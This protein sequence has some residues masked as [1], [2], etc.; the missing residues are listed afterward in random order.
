[1]PPGDFR[2]EVVECVGRWALAERKSITGSSGEQLAATSRRRHL[3]L[4]LL[5]LLHLVVT[6]HQEDDGAGGSSGGSVRLVSR[7]V[8]Q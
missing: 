4:L 8:G 3:P 7:A 5:L 1:M 6:P 2:L